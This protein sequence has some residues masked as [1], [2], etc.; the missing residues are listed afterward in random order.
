MGHTYTLFTIILYIYMYMYI[1]II[2]F[3]SESD[4]KCSHARGNLV[5]DALCQTPMRT[6]GVSHI[7]VTSLG[8]IWMMFMMSV[9]FLN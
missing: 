3:K 1:Y 8:W 2:W 6:R 7:H 9:L 4:V 5:E